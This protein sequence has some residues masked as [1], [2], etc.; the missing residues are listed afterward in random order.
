LIDEII[1]GI[2]GSSIAEWAQKRWPPRAR[3]A[4]EPLF[5]QLQSR[6]RVLY[7]TSGVS[8]GAAFILFFLYLLAGGWRSGVWQIEVLFG[9]P[10]FMMTAVAM[11]GC[12]S[13]GL[14]RTRE[15]L[16]YW[17]LKHKLNFW[18]LVSFFVPLSLL[19]IVSISSGLV[20]L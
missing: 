7:W 1:S 18:S 11:V 12:A 17:E 5:E 9:L 4:D 14:A 8:G 3:S 10:F 20:A 13:G 15:F 19:S 16:R 2:F 6:N